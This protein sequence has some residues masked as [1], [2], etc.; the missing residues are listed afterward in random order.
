M[1]DLQL[2]DIHGDQVSHTSDF[3]DKIYTYAI[4]LIK[5]GKAYSDDT[6]QAQVRL[7]CTLLV[8]LPNFWL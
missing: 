6:E 5:E 1:E 8:S 3:F 7:Q 2:L 4:Q